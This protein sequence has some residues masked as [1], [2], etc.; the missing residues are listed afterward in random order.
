LI[1]KKALNP[2]S[3]AFEWGALP[4]GSFFIDVGGGLGGVT[5]EVL[6]KFPRLKGIVQDLPE[7]V[8]NGKKV[9]GSFIKMIATQLTYTVFL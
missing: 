6:K 7:T 5:L 4:E 8:S 9:I 2:V 3:L 1:V